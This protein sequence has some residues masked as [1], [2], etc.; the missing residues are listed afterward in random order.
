MERHV[1]CAEVGGGRRRHMRL[2][3]AVSVYAAF[4]RENRLLSTG[5]QESA[6]FHGNY[7]SSVQMQSGQG[8]VGHLAVAAKRVAVLEHVV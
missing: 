6:G 8:R 3:R 7:L 4:W 5:L 1:R 2:P